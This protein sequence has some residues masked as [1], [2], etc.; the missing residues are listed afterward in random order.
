VI[1][2][3]QAGVVG[4]RPCLAYELV[5]DARP[6]DEAWRGLAAA[7]RLDLLEEVIDGVAQAHEQGVVHRDLKP[8]NVLVDAA[9]RARITDFGLAWIG[10]DVEHLTQTGAFMGT[11]ATM[12]PEQVAGDK[13]QRG[14][15]TDVWA[16][17]V[18]L[19]LALTDEWPFQA[20]TVTELL[21]RIVR[22]NPLPPRAVSSVVSRELARSSA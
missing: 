21:A 8:D 5:E 15:T 13:A 20:P 18:L 6:L 7:S 19:Y 4:G 11:P 3:Y 14:P 9:G 16:L 2:I 12:A 10:P 17:G 1:G 22:A